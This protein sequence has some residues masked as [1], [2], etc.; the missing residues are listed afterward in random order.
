MDSSIDIGTTKYALWSQSASQSYLQ[1]SL[2]IGDATPSAK[3]EVGDGT[4]SLQVS[5][6]GDLLFVDA[7]GGSSITGPAGGALTVA[8]GTSQD[9]ILNSADTIEL[10]DATN[11]TGI[12]TI[13]SI[14]Q[15]GSAT[16]TTYSRL[17][18]G[19]TGHTLDAANDLLITDDLEVDGDAFFDGN[20]TVV[21]TCSGCG[22]M[23]IGGAIT[24]ATQGSILFAGVSGVLAQ[25]NTNFFWDNTNKNLKLG[26]PAEVS[27][28]SLNVKI[29]TGNSYN[30]FL[31]GTGGVSIPTI[32]FKLP[33][34]AGVAMTG[35][36]GGFG[37]NNIG[38]GTTIGLVPGYPDAYIQTHTSSA[39]KLHIQSHNGS[40]FV[41]TITV[42]NGLVGIATASPAAGMELDVAGQI[43]LDL[44]GSQTSVALCGSHTAA[45][46]ASVSD[47]EIVDCTGTPAAD[48]MEYYSVDASA[49]MGDV[50]TTSD[51]YV[52]TKDEDRLVKLV[53]TSKAYQ[54]NIIGVVSD[55]T[56][57]GDFNSIGYNIKEEDNPLPIALNGRVKVKVTNENGVIRPGDYLTSS[58]DF[59]GYAMRATE[60]GLVIGKAL[61]GFDG[62]SQMIMMFVDVHEY[63]PTLSELLQGNNTNYQ[64]L[65]D[66]NLTD[67][68]VYGK[69][70]V[71][72]TLFVATLIVKDLKADRVET[73]EL[74]VE[75][76]CINKD[77][78]N[79]LLEQWQN[80][81]SSSPPQEQGSQGQVIPDAV[82]PDQPTP[83][84][85]IPDQPIPEPSP[86]TE[87]PQPSS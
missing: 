36:S 9:I 10:Q 7:D 72:D 75:D 22:G 3:L 48:Y 47:V 61:E 30:L 14:L 68:K 62:G 29:T 6:V 53:K 85:V 1:G 51:E 37:F 4:D 54:T 82:I 66:L 65:V 38:E 78:F 20:L 81:G 8:S 59:P 31:E 25:D 11:I 77:Q 32:G 80:S 50:V 56:K 58:K 35:S 71:T 33:G 52:F 24:S 64:E 2:G 15:V 26:N 57:A 83:D 28:A 19:T 27:T 86:P 34:F 43:Q 60:A 84:A 63:T 16:A 41:E 79:A 23:S 40:A 76:I 74:C 17:G 87:E 5:S 46:G 18:T 67:A 13:S 73:K 42:N 49:E 55:K 69:L 39:G 45:S 12:A 70:I 44:A 21:G